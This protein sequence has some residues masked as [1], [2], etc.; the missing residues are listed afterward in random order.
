MYIIYIQGVLNATG[1]NITVEAKETTVTEP[2]HV[3][4]E[5]FTLAEFWA[6][7]TVIKLDVNGTL[8]VVIGEGFESGMFYAQHRVP[9]SFL[10]G[11]SSLS[12]TDDLVQEEEDGSSNQAEPSSSPVR[13]STKGSTSWDGLGSLP[14]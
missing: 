8:E 10:G 7:F 9:G 14:W 3:N 5:Q 1:L 12:S 6:L 4:I 11:P 2:L 13:R